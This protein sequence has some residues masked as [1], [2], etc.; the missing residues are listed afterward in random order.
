MKTT[1]HS[2]VAHSDD[3]IEALKEDFASLRRDFTALVSESATEKMDQASQALKGVVKQTSK[4]AGAV[5]KQL[6]KTAA[7][8]PVATI[9]VAAAVG[10]IGVKAL[11]WMLR[12]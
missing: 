2:R 11:S 10:A 9:L 12:R 1:T 6:S 7:E 4:Q 8:R 5:H 3:P